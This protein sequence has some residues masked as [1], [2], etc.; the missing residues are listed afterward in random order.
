MMPRNRFAV[1]GLAWRPGHLASAEEVDMEM[2]DGFASVWAVVDN[3]AETG[4]E[5]KLLGD[6]AGNQN[7]VAQ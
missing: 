3:D 1:F 5:F 4:F 2:W 7:K 6:L